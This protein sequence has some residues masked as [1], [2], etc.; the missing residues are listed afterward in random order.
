MWPRCTHTCGTSCS[1][2]YYNLY[3]SGGSLCQHTSHLL[4]WICAGWLAALLPLPLQLLVLLLQ[5]LLLAHARQLPVCRCPR[6]PPWRAA[7]PWWC[8]SD[9]SVLL[10]TTAAVA[11]QCQPLGTKA[12]VVTEAA[13]PYL[14]LNNSARCVEEQKATVGPGKGPAQDL[15]AGLHAPLHMQPRTTLDHTR[16]LL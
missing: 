2:L 7:G 1:S 4:V 15:C 12:Q 11:P 9:C 14:S 6:D 10:A 13:A 8:R 16:M 3:I 5:P